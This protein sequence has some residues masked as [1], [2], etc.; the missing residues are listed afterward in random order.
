MSTKTTFK[1]IAL[2]T[3]A[4]MGFGLLSVVP[5]TATSQQDTLS[6]SATATTMAAG[7]TSA[8]V[9]LTQSFLGTNS[10]TMSVVA[11]LVSAPTGNAVMPVL[12]NLLGSTVGGYVSNISS[13]NLSG[14]I[15]DTVIVGTYAVAT[16]VYR[17]TFSPTKPGTYVLSFKAQNGS[18]SSPTTV[19]VVA[20]AVTWTVTVPSGTLADTTS[21][22][23]TRAAGVSTGSTTTVSVAGAGSA[24]LVASVEVT[25]LIA[26]V[27]TTGSTVITATLT[28]AGTLS[29]AST[30]GGLTA[31]TGLKT[32]TLS[33]LGAGA[34][35]I[36]LWRD[37]TTGSASI[38]ISINGTA[39]GTAT[40]TLTG[41][42][43]SCCNTS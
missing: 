36:G 20:P 22:L 7:S 34:G 43:N 37:G 3:V 11:S 15:T 32:I 1:R 4:A 2:V 6:L 30:I 19:A 10:D 26:S 41:C 18:Y 17:V 31:T 5:S 8:S 16:A 29:G 35:F 39:V 28:G 12:T 24:T 42:N 23:V 25:P 21:T 13:D 38:A 9:D 40:A 27:A 33:G 14:M